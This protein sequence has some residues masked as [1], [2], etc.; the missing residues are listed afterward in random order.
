L[1]PLYQA[2]R[3]RQVLVL[4]YR[5]FGAV[6]AWE[7][8]VQPYLLKQYN[9]RWFLIG[10]GI[11][12][13]SV[14]G[15]YITAVKIGSAA[16]LAGIKT[17]DIIQGID[18]VDVNSSVE[19]SERIARHHPGDKITL[20]Y[21]RGTTVSTAD[22]TLKEQESVTDNQSAIADATIAQKLGAS[23][24]PL[25][26]AFKQRYR[27]NTGLAVTD[28]DPGGLFAEIGIQRGSIILRINGQQINSVVDIKKTFSA[29]T[30]GIARFECLT[31]DGSIV[32]FNLSLG[33]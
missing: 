20:K 21:K 11:K 30:N 2:I 27:M 3:G 15:A 25:S 10:Q 9:H 19:L 8:T 16:A 24:S 26:S 12:P 18:D 22:V 7:A 31:P 1:G 17:G 5:P 32:V 6:E 14:K 4:R 13:G 23:F 29:A 28:V 33:A